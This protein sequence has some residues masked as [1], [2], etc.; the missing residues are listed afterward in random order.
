M[1]D[2]NNSQ[3][4]QNNKN[5]ISKGNKTSEILAIIILLI[6]SFFL[7]VKYS[8]NIKNHANWLFESKEEELEM[9]DITNEDIDDLGSS[10]DE[11]IIENN[12]AQNQN[13]NNVASGNQPI[14]NPP[15]AP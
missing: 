12:D 3:T 13:N 2:N 5:R 7:G 10:I 6:I 15:V 9:P 14:A 11:N 8:D 1:T 4:K